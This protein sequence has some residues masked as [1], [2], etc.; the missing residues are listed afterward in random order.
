MS[1]CYSS[2]Q[3]FYVSVD[4]IIF[5]VVDG[6]LNVLLTKRKFAPERGKW[7]LMG[8]FVRED[9]SLDDAASR[10]LLE[11]T[12]LSHTFM[13]QVK[14]FGEVDR[15]PGARVISVAYYALLT[16]DLI[17]AETLKSHSARWHD[18]SNL[19]DLG[20]DHEEMIAKA[21]AQLCR[22]IS[23]EPFAFR[24]LPEQFTLT[25]LQ[26]L[27]ELI[28]DETFDKRN[29]RKRIA[30]NP[31]ITPTGIIDKTGSRR[32]AMLYRFDEAIYLKDGRFK[33]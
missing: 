28:F 15:D 14:A 13:R 7:S 33:M 32:G 11:L 22:R 21:R 24:L 4:C 16:P 9:E 12:G 18:I 20:F 2:H 17:N 26:N 27:Y 25:R 3:K 31:C 1:I 8:G 10:V 30:E 29:F 6:R 23:T 19:P 5:G